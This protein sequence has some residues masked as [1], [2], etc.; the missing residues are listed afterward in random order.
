VSSDVIAFIK[1][2]KPQC[3]TGENT[4]V[5][6]LTDLHQGL[7]NCIIDVSTIPIKLGDI[8]IKPSMAYVD[9]IYKLLS[10]LFKH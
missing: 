4:P 3:K 9:S 7:I 6:S 2:L 5:I 8:T 1:K 10:D